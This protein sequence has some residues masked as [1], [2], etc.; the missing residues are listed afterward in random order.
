MALT[1][2]FDAIADPATIKLGK[3]APDIFLLAAK[4]IGLSPQEC[5]GIEDAQSWDQSNPC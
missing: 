5:I 4:E 2:F 1:P 3:P